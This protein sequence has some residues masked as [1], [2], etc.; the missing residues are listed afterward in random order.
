[1]KEELERLRKEAKTETIS[2][3]K[4]AAQPAV[5]VRSE[6]EKKI[7]M[8]KEDNT[9]FIT[10]DKA[11]TGKKVQEELTRVLNPRTAKV[12]INRMRTAGKAL[13]IEAASK[14]DLEK[15]KNHEQV[16]KHFKCELPRK[17]K[18]LVIIYD[19]ASA[20]KEEDVIEDI[21]SQ[22]FEHMTAEQFAEAFKVRFRTGPRGRSTVHYVVEVSPEI[23]NVLV[24]SKIYVGFS[25][26]NAKDYIVVP[27]CMKCQDLG[28][29]AK[30]C[31]KEM[32]C[33]HC[34]EMHERKNCG[35][36]E[37]PKTCIPCKSRGKG[38]CGKEQRDCPTHKMLVDRLIQKTD[39]GN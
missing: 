12:R 10:C 32:A 35:K 17:R 36:V 37:Q 23:R 18:P 31:A 6:A 4:V 30:H 39:Y 16:K 8:R 33:S 19:V 1:M 3:A 15:I 13:I 22:N 5:A 2:Y 21:R 27:K 11:A 28:H 26:L 29:V 38:N 7:A 9:I 34:G 25:A 20:D 24:R 14:Q